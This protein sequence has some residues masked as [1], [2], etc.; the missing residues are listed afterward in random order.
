MASCNDCSRSFRTSGALDDHQRD[1]RHCFCHHCNRF[2]HTAHGL[3]SHFG[4]LHSFYCPECDKR[5][6]FDYALSQH[7][8]STGHA[9]CHLCE[10]SF[11][12]KG[13]LDDHRRALHLFKCEKCGKE[14]WSKEAKA[15][16]STGEA[17]LN[18]LKDYGVEEV[19]ILVVWRLSGAGES[20][21][22]L[23]YIR[24]Y[25]QDYTAVF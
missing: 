21:L 19:R 24:D 13:A 25:S 14:L 16:L 18:N 12:C 5:F 1:T 7:Q 4:S 3:E 6:D 2:F 17:A 22:V 11:T 8:K 23:N 20:Q 15:A 9:Y 10:K